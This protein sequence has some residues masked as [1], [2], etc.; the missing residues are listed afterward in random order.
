LCA[1]GPFRFPV[2]W[3]FFLPLTYI[4]YSQAGVEEQT[5]V[6]CLEYGCLGMVLSYEWLFV[7]KG[8]T[9]ED[10]M[11][12][13][14]P[15][16]RWLQATIPARLRIKQHR[17]EAHLRRGVQ[18]LDLGAGHGGLC[19]A[20]RANGFEVLPV[21]VKDG[22]FFEDV[23]P[24]LYDGVKLP[25]PD[26]HFDTTLLI[27]VLHHT[28]DPELVLREAMRV[29]AHRLVV[30]EDIYSNPLQ[31]YLTYFTDSL[32]NLEFHGHPHTNRSDAEWR[33]TFARLGWEIESSES[34]RTLIFFRQVIYVLQPI[35]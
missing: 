17:I 16:R 22:S 20:L 27:T 26:A 23:R 32:V 25:F 34:F 15:L 31:R 19:K 33:A 5:W 4:A 18:L 21:D 10:W 9:L 24:V 8:R 13:A 29:S 11:R 6:L 3:T 7:R 28:P 30:M 14:P 2:I 1:L 12:A 35:K